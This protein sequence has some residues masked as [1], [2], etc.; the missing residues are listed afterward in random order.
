M[1]WLEILLWVA[2]DW[3]MG[4]HSAGRQIGGWAQLGRLWTLGLSSHMVFHSQGG[5]TWR[6][7]T[8]MGNVPGGWKGA[9]RPC[10]GS[11]PSRLLCSV[12]QRTS[13]GYLRSQGW[14][15]RVHFLMG[16]AI[17][18]LCFCLIHQNPSSGHNYLQLLPSRNWIHISTPW[19]GLVSGHVLNG[20]MSGKTW[21][22]ASDQGLALPLLEHVFATWRSLA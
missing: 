13:R 6:L 20:R 15:S 10:L 21:A 5:Q 2:L 22:T 8:G 11:W 4:Q 17:N 12:G 9:V 1:G 14:R 3:L 7:H 19:S 18:T 16:K